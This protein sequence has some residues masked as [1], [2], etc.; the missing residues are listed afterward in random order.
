MASSPCLPR[1]AVISY[2]PDLNRRRFLQ[3]CA[4]GLA[5]GLEP[6]LRAD[7]LGLPIGLQLYTVRDACQRDLPGT[8]E[9]VARIG[10]RE[11]EPGSFDYYHRKPGELR[12]LFS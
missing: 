5:A 3:T 8:L 7:P 1:S 10:Y 9:K 4:L 11:V 2:A 12:K 6:S